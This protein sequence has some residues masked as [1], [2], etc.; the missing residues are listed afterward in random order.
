V[1]DGFAFALAESQTDCILLSGDD[2]LRTLAVKRGME[3]HGVLWV[4]DQLQANRLASPMTILAVLRK[5][6]E[7]ASVRLPR[8]ELTIYIK[9]YEWLVLL[10]RP[11]GLSQHSLYLGICWEGFISLAV[12][13]HRKADSQ[14]DN[15]RC[16][17]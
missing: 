12:G 1:H 7:D 11:L 16:T 13:H 10:Y 8:R 3:V 5:F 9:R 4:L 2:A 14:N 17:E 15:C 6:L